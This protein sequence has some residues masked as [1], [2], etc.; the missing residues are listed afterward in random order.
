[1]PPWPST[2]VAVISMLLHI[3]EVGGK[4][5]TQHA[6]FR[7][8]LLLVFILLFTAPN[9]PR[10]ACKCALRSPQTCFPFSMLPQGHTPLLNQSRSPPLYPFH[11]SHVRG[12]VYKQPLCSSVSCFLPFSLCKPPPS[13]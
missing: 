3:G 8:S 12:F 6:P 9:T 1:M 11:C 7:F 5:L 13:Q 4:I 10:K 2:S